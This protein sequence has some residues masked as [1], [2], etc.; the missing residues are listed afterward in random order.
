MSF[1][2]QKI[3]KDFPIFNK[4]EKL[5]YLDNASTT[6]KPKV[7]LNELINYY[8]NYNANVHRA[9]Y[10]LAETSTLKYENARKI[11]ANF[12]NANSNEII[13]TKS[14]TESINIISYALAFNNFHEGDSSFFFE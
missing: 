10:Q 7:V 12:I 13:F 1:D 14:A 2:V 4:S 6:Q 9:I 8:S 11:I 3:R 5:I